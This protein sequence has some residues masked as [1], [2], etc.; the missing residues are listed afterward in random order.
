MVK[1]LLLLIARITYILGLRKIRSPGVAWRLTA[2]DMFRETGPFAAE[3]VSQ[4]DK[5]WRFL[6]CPT[7]CR[8]VLWVIESVDTNFT[9]RRHQTSTKKFWPPR[10]PFRVDGAK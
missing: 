10:L 6:Q 3:L 4:S 1:C 2:Y 8:V 5:T 9:W 7:L